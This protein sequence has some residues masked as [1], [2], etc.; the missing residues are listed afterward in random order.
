M[1]S[2]CA[3]VLWLRQISW[4]L[5]AAGPEIS[6]VLLLPL[7][8]GEEWRGMLERVGSCV[9]VWTDNIRQLV[10]MDLGIGGNFCCS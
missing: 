8:G 7:K 4:N 1:Q 9:G 5:R 6:Q 10:R 2:F 3:P